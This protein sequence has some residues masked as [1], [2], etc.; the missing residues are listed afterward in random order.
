MNL[1]LSFTIA[2]RAAIAAENLRPIGL[3]AALCP[4]IVCW[5]LQ[6]ELCPTTMG[7]AID[8]HDTGRWGMGSCSSDHPQLTSR[9]ASGQLPLEGNR[10][11]LLATR[12]AKRKL[13][14]MGRRPG[15]FLIHPP[16]DFPD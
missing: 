5:Y 11:Q 12:A 4:G 2:L 3:M 10:Q 6:A 9:S 7:A 14:R 15:E 1:Q 8:Q 13:R 16:I